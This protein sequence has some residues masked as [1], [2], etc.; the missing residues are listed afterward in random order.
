MGKG[1]GAQQGTGRPRFGL[2]CV[3]FGGSKKSWQVQKAVRWKERWT[4]SSKGNNIR[5]FFAITVSPSLSYLLSFWHLARYFIS[6][7]YDTM[8]LIF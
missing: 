7:I 1:I 4:E 8:L 3:L 5:T 2:G 6:F